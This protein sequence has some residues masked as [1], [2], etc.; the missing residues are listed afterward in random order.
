MVKARWIAVV[1]L[2]LSGCVHAPEAKV[3]TRDPQYVLPGSNG[4]PELCIGGTTDSGPL[5][6][7]KPALSLR[8]WPAN[9]QLGRAYVVTGMFDGTRLRVTHVHRWDDSRDKA[10]PAWGDSQN[11]YAT[12]CKAPT[13]G[14]RVL[15]PTK[16]TSKQIDDMEFA[17][18]KLP[19]FTAFWWDFSRTPAGGADND[20]NYATANVLVDRD[21]S[22]AE[23]KMRRV[24]G[25]ALC[26]TRSRH[27]STE[28]QTINS[29]LDDVRGHLV[30]SDKWDSINVLVAYDDGSIQRWANK[31]FG[32][33]YV[34]VT[35]ALRDA[36]KR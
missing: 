19:G 23:R 3:V 16:T 28:Q 35:S 4:K 36:P 11:D 1:A 26:V 15:D 5:K 2:L 24:W 27:S 14:W 7:A 20:P 12:R 33:G 31:H 18:Q 21:V 8:R 32:T 30:T 9:A 10:K 13:G 34:R 22:G 25:G 29:R 6:C 17:A